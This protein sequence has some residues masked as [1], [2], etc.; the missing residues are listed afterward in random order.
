MCFPDLIFKSY[1]ICLFFLFFIFKNIVTYS[2]LSQSLGFHPLIYVPFFPA[3][4]V[5]VNYQVALVSLLKILQFLSSY[6]DY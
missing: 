4:A 6:L 5:I 2:Y 1:C 3:L